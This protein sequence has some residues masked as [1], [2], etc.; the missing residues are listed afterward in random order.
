MKVN[1]LIRRKKPLPPD[2]WTE[3]NGVFGIVVALGYGG[4]PQHPTAT[5]LYPPTGH[6]HEIARTLLEVVNE[7]R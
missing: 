1:D 5:I 4:N 7:G 2:Y 6:Q 3:K